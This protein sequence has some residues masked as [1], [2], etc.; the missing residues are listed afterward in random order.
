MWKDT[1]GLPKLLDSEGGGTEGY[2]SPRCG[3]ANAAMPIWSDAEEGGLVTFVE[4]L[5]KLA[6]FT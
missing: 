3:T 1:V 4:T 5:T 2:D 6:G